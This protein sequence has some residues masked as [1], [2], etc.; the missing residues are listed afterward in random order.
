[1]K[2]EE[3]PVTVTWNWLILNERLSEE[4]DFKFQILYTTLRDEIFITLQYGK[5]VCKIHVF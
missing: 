5:E 2:F 1:M 4:T 3:L